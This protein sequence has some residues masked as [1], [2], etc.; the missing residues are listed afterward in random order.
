MSGTRRCNR[1]GGGA[2][3]EGR[4]GAGGAEHWDDAHGDLFDSRGGLLDAGD[5]WA[6]VDV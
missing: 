1:S 2:G 6:G 3:A 5:V 4:A